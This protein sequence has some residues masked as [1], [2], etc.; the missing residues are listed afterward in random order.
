[1]G[2][3]M[4]QSGLE[5]ERFQGPADVVRVSQYRLASHLSLAFILYTG[6]YCFSIYG[7]TIVSYYFVSVFWTTVHFQDFCGQRWI[8]FYLHWNQ[9]RY[10]K[11]SQRWESW[12]ICPKVLLSS[13]LSP[14][15]WDCYKSVSLEPS[16]FLDGSSPKART[17]IHTYRWPRW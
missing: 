4:V 14:V 2:W 13:L 7:K 17:D 6:W 5:H 16:Y 9:T 3:Y 11:G 12:R 10:P 1:M 8:T 15:S